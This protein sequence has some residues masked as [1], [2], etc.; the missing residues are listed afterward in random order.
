M[1]ADTTVISAL[2]ALAAVVLSPVATLVAARWQNKTSLDTTKRE[3]AATVVSANRQKWIDELRNS[4]AAF[5]S[6]SGELLYP[7]LA[8]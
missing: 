7:S 2:T 5:Q 3:M 6:V 8:R 1:T 4:L